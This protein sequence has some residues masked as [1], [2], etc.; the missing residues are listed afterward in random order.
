MPTKSKQPAPITAKDTTSEALRVILKHNFNYLVQWEET[1]RSWENIEGVHQVRVSFRKIRSIFSLFRKAVPKSTTQHW[2]DE[3]RWISTQLGTA[4]DLDVF[5][6]E[7]LEVIADKLPF[8]GK[9][10]LLDLAMEQRA[11][12]YTEQVAS[13]LDSKRYAKFKVEFEQW[14]EEKAWEKSELKKKHQIHLKMNLLVFSR[15]V[16]DKQERRVLTKGSQINRKSADKMH[17]LRIECKKLRYA[18]EFFRP[19]FNGM[20]DFIEHMKGIQDILG[21]MNDVAVMHDLLELLLTDSIDHELLE[22]SAAVIG[23]RTCEYYMLLNNFDGYWD[24]FTE[25]NHPWWK[26]RKAK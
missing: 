24:D 17:R 14:F 9:D 22:F 13:M 25:A 4:R 21:I 18:A 3:I 23:W 11:K 7:G 19:V 20:D 12:A 6:D 2:N 15:L 8:V 10:K 5:I 16:L 1:A 26:N